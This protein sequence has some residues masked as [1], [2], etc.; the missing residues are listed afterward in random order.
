MNSVVK[1]IPTIHHKIKGILMNHPKSLNPIFLF[2]SILI[3]YFCNFILLRY[4]APFCLPLDYY[5]LKLTR[6]N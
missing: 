2:A 4:P 1:T 5:L 3:F 6:D